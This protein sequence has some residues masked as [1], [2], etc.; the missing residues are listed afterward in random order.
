MGIPI[1]GKSLKGV[2]DQCKRISR[3]RPSMNVRR[4]GRVGLHNQNV[5]DTAMFADMDQP[6]QGGMF[7]ETA[8]LSEAFYDQL[9]RHSARFKMPQS[10][11][12][13]ITRW[14]STSMPGGPTGF[15][16]WNEPLS[17]S[18]RAMKGQFGV[19]LVVS[20]VVV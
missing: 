15:I 4:G 7:V 9:R 19:A 13:P 8:R 12:S 16:H 5:V 10:A 11:R 1:G 18:W 14:P 17:V 2:R 20:L 3:C 6:H